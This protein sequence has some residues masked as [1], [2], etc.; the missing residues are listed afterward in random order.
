MWNSP[1]QVDLHYDIS[2]F[3]FSFFPNLPS[4]HPIVTAPSG[5]RSMKETLQSRFL[6]TI[7]HLLTNGTT[8]PTTYKTSLKDLHTSAV[9]DAISQLAPNP[10]LQTPAPLVESEE[11]SL[12][13]AHRTALS[14]LRSGHCT[15]LKS[16]R[17]RIGMDGAS[18]PAPP[19]TALSTYPDIYLPAPPT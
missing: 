12:P 2:C 11:L 7:D 13:R 6:P 5:I 19:A 15:F 3:Q 14:Q 16:H 1:G 4:A 9:R 10:V 18:P 17:A 8:D